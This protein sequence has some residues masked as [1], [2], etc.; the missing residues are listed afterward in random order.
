MKLQNWKLL[1]KLEALD[2]ETKY[3][4]SS[5]RSNPVYSDCISK[6]KLDDC[7][8][9]QDMDTLAT[10][11]MNNYEAIIAR[12]EERLLDANSSLKILKNEIETKTSALS[13]VSF[14]SKLSLMSGNLFTTSLLFRQGK[15][16]I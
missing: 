10:R 6:S 16:T 11:A 8:E 9:V 5:W 3:P 13:K 12:L 14:P 15:R 4:K 7:L 2:V 1:E